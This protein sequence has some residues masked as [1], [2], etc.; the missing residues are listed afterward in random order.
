M[1]ELRGLRNIFANYQ[2]GLQLV[3]QTG[4]LEGGDGGEPVGS[5][6]GIGDG[7]FLNSAV[8]QCRETIL[9]EIEGGAWR[10]PDS[11][12]SLCVD[13]ER[14]GFGEPSGFQ[15]AGSNTIS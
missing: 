8:E 5:M 13:R 9:F 6:F 3:V 14:A 2:L 1:H 15:F 11:D 7:N 10:S 4:L 12:A